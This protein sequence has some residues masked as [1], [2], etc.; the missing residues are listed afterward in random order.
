MRTVEINPEAVLAAAAVLPKDQPV[1]MINLLRYREHADY[2]DRIGLPPCSGR[3]AYYERYASISFPL[4]QKLGGKVF[5]LG[6]VSASVIG[7]PDER[8]D[9]ALLVEY[10]SF[11]A[12]QA[13]F[14]HPEYIANLFHRTAALEDSRL[15]ATTTSSGIG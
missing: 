4:V 14:S 13:L 1:V 6:K 8:W 9:D 15:I 11:S 5:W 7:P 3:E 12:L 2:G 10:P